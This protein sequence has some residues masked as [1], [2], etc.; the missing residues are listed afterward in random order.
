MKVYKGTAYRELAI[1]FELT[2]DDLSDRLDRQTDQEAIFE[3]LQDEWFEAEL[4]DE[5]TDT[6]KIEEIPKS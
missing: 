5:Y 1:R 3:C 2:E 4:N 6:I